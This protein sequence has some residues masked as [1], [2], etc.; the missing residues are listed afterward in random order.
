MEK[1]QFG[2]DWTEQ[3]LEK[4]RKY[5]PAYM[6]VLAGR[7]FTI[8]YI[9]A[10]A[11]TGYRNMRQWC[12]EERGLF[13]ELDDTDMRRYRSGSARIA[14]ETEPPF[15]RFVFIEKDKG[16]CRE[17]ERLKDEFPILADRIAI[18]NEDANTCI[19]SM[20]SPSKNWKSHRAVMF[21]DPF[22][23]QVRWESIELIATTK[24]IDLW[25]LFPIG[26]V[27][28]LLE[29]KQ[30]EH[31][32]FAACLD[33]TFGASD[34]R[35]AFYVTKEEVSL[36]GESLVSQEKQASFDSIGEYIIKRLK[37][38]FEGVVEVPYILRN[39]KTPLFMLCFAVGNPKGKATALKIARDILM[40]D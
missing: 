5:L 29:K 32:E 38:V 34:W 27:N 6:K 30:C 26:S 33:R 35:E 22:G 37:T 12:P 24:A 14:L 2:G 10:F 21:L 25:Y 18:H 1:Q 23:M 11:G 19:A 36:F 3:K 9:D 20:C 31:A 8:G 15:D 7:G 13:D 16:K 4:V 40:K 39:S 17:L 28:R